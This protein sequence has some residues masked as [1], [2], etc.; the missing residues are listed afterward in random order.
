[1]MKKILSWG[2]MAVAV[3]LFCSCS[4]EEA[5]ADS[6]SKG[7]PFTLVAAPESRTVNDGLSTKWA[8][9]DAIN[10]F[11][12]P[13]S[14]SADTD[15]AFVSDGQF[16]ISSENLET[17]TFT[18]TL[19]GTLDETTDWYAFYPYSQRLTSPVN[20]SEYYATVGSTAAG[21][22]TQDGNNS[23]AH[24]AGSNYPLYGIAAGCPADAKPSIRMMQAA[25]LV[26]VEVTNPAEAAE[27]VTV[28]AVEFTAPT[29][30]VGTYYI[31][32]GGAKLSFTGSGASYV[33]N[34]AKLAVSN[35]SAIAPGESATFYIG[36]KPFSTTEETL[37]VKVSA[38]NDNLYVKTFEAVTTTFSSGLIKTV[39]VDLGTAE[40]E[41]PDTYK[42]ITT[43][44]ELTTGEYMIVYEAGS[45]AADASKAVSTTGIGANNAG[46]AVTIAD[47][48]IQTAADA[49]TITVDGETA[50]IQ[51]TAGA[52]LNSSSA[53]N[54]LVSAA[55][56]VRNCTITV[57]SDGSVT[58]ANFDKT[59]Q[60]CANTTG[61]N[62]YFR[63]YKNA[64][65]SGSAYI[66]F[67]LYKKVE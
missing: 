11:H 7:T 12:A 38:T 61:T 15:R 52:Y 21:S 62:C 63:F 22:Q 41:G 5:P 3:A 23:M 16:T 47:G 39:K 46:I 49:F 60:F 29:D 13:T 37:S 53:T 64:T 26:A 19:N 33:S 34:T 20:D 9:G 65:V 32:F 31:N 67:S 28:S 10:V 27:A 59:T 66:P 51:N 36:I 17:A 48:E 50:T 8:A 18:G 25:A 6:A 35:G 1:M 4:K 44:E 55:E 43:Q 30:I 57:N 2:A 56:G 24:I 58:I 45:L 42:K 54:G 14:T 40:V